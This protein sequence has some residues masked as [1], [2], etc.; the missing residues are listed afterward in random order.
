MH[1]AEFLLSMLLIFLTLI[2]AKIIEAIREDTK[3]T[4]EWREEE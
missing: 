3:Q 2:I 1:G 4:I